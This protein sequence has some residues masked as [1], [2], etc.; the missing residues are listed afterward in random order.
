MNLYRGGFCKVLSAH[1][2]QAAATD[3]PDSEEQLPQPVSGIGPLLAFRETTMGMRI[4]SGGAAAAPA[5]SSVAQWQ[6][7]AA[8]APVRASVSPAATQ[9]SKPTATSGN[10]VNLV[11]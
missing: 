9:P 2:V 7:R 1:L 11:A 10:H 6:Q 5:Q 3:N 4:P 8:Q